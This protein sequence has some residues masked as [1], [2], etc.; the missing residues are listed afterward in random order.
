MIAP[1]L[2]NAE[3][4]AEI[5]AGK[6]DYVMLDRMNYHYADW[7]YR[8]NGLEDEM[9]DDFFAG[10]NGR[11]PRHSRSWELGVNYN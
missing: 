4:L 8:K 1:I 2:P 7:V 6:V 9:T 10:R 3:S 11:F 5:L